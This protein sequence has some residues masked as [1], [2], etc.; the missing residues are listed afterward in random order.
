[1]KKRYYASLNLWG[2]LSRLVTQKGK[3]V[4]C[5][6]RPNNGCEEDYRK[7]STNSNTIKYLCLSLFQINWMGFFFTL[8]WTIF[9]LELKKCSFSFMKMQTPFTSCLISNY[10]SKKIILAYVACLCLIEEINIRLYDN[11][12]FLFPW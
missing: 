10:P 4:C 9:S 7:P 1:M 11:A 2:G 8:Y 6:T 12:M 5:V 3:R